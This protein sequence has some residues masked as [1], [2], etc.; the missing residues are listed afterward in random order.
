MGSLNPDAEVCSGASGAERGLR[1]V[2][3]LGT[4]LGSGHGVVTH[5]TAW[6]IDYEGAEQGMGTEHPAEVGGKRF[7]V[8]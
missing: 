4:L 8:P 3:A 6:R 5:G 2:A 1:A 7:Q